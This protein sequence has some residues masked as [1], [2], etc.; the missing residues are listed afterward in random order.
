[1]LDHFTPQTATN[2]VRIPNFQGRPP[3]VLGGLGG[4]DGGLDRGTDYCS[5]D[6]LDHPP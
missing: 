4:L 6:N 3:T 1:M 2:K 5:D